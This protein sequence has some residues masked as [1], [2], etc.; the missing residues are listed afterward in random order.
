[1][2][3]NN[4]MGPHVRIKV[5]TNMLLTFG[6]GHDFLRLEFERGPFMGKV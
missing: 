6:L 4:I 1:M 2:A 5:C 3:S